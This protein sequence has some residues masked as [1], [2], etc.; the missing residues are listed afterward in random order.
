MFQLAALSPPAVT[1]N[2]ST[3]TVPLKSFGSAGRA[4]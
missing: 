4:T 2:H 3:K 1:F